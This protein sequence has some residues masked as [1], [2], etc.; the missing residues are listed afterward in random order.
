[1]SIVSSG[2]ISF[3]DLYGKSALTPGSQVFTANGTYTVI[4]H[5]SHVM[6]RNVINTLNGAKEIG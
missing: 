3:S 5:P 1:M 2:A 6:Q 4:N